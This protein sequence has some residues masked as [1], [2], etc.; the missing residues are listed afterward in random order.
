MT[1][2]K[3]FGHRLRKD[4]VQ[5]KGL[6]VLLLLVVIYFLIFHYYPMYGAQIACRDFAPKKGIWGSKWVGLKHFRRFFDSVFAERL[7][8]NT[9]K[10]NL[11]NLLFGFPAP[12]ILA[13]MLN[14]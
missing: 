7:I 11:K 10:I 1:K 8:G 3:T 13:L 6:Y 12:I 5:H 4:I 2:L 14:D 9:L